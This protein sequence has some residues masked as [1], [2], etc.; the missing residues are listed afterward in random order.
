[1]DQ[2]EESMMIKEAERE[3]KVRKG[4]TWNDSDW[5]KGKGKTALQ[6]TGPRNQGGGKA[7]GKKGTPAEKAALK[8]DEHAA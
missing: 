7:K 5:K 2:G 4:G 6:D 8:K 1:M 3:D